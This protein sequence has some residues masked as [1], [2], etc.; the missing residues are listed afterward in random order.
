MKLTEILPLD[1]LIEFEKDL[2]ERSGLNIS[3]FDSE[4]ELL[5]VYKE[6]ANKLC[7]VIK[8]NEKGGTVICINANNN[9]SLMSKKSRKPVTEECD[10]G[11]LKFTVPVF[12]GDEYLGVVTGCGLLPEDGE[13]DTFLISKM[14]G[15][16]ED[17]L[18]GPA[19]GIGVLSEEK[20]G[21]LIDYIQDELG[22]MIPGYMRV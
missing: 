6:W 10:A 7:P 20:I 15:L 5:L 18:S 14:T 4:G 22:R 17:E 13:V 1:K 21:S 11:L 2:Y 19:A 8:N 12:V 16:D 3:V 9:I